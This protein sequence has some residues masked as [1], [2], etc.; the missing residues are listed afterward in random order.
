[1]VMCVALSEDDRVLATGGRDRL[2]YV[3]G[4]RTIYGN[5]HRLKH[6]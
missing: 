3:W 5:L 4:V 1:M 6:L 2:V